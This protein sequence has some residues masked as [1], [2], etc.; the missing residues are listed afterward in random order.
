MLIEHLVESMTSWRTTT[1]L[2]LPRLHNLVGTLE[3]IVLAPILSRE[4]LYHL[5]YFKIIPH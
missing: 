2:Y 1:L 4:L 3:A 5:N